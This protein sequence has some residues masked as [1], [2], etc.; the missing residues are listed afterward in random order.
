LCVTHKSTYFF[1]Q[2]KKRA[3]TSLANGWYACYTRT[4]TDIRCITYI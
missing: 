4:N 1:G 2:Y 3:N